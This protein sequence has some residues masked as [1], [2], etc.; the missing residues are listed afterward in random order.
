MATREEIAQIFPT[1][2]N[3]RFVPSK[4]EGVNAIIQFNLSGENGGLYW[5]KIVEGVCTAGEGQAENPKMTLKAAADDWHAVS[6]GKIN[7]MQAFMS[8]KLKIE[9]DMGLAMKMQ[10]MFQQ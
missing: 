8:G 9:G 2:A 4:A 7:A 10:T 6:T 1:M 5:L 3:E